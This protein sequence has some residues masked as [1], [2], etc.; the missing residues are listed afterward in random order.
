[1]RD[2]FIF[3]GV[4][5]RDFQIWAFERNT[6]D[7]PNRVYDQLNIPGK[8]GTVLIDG[9][10]YGNGTIS[11][12]CVIYQH[13]EQNLDEFRNFLM[14]RTGYR[15]LE[16][17]F[18]KDEFYQAVF[19]ESFSPTKSDGMVKFNLNFSRKPQRF[20]KAGELAETFDADG[21][22]FNPTYHPSQPLIRV[23]GTG[24]LEVGGT[25]IT[26]SAS[27]GYT[28]I[29][30]EIMECFRDASSRNEYVSFSGNDF[31]ILEPGANG[32][33]L[34]SGITRVRITPRWYRL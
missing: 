28:D 23:T 1:M 26:I 8:S 14:S 11:Y 3:D 27:S 13:G 12:S 10:R 34:G 29:D 32:V 30:C 15:R 21:T 18:H 5:S 33:V 6:D 24:T 31:P 19:L 9:K 2:H 22:I 25:S 4:D 17:T 7:A 16:D 20:L